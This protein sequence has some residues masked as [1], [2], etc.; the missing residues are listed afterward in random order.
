MS[1]LA[2]ESLVQERMVYKIGTVQENGFL[3]GTGVNSPLGVFNASD[4]GIGTDRDSSTNMTATGIQADG[5]IDAVGMLKAQYR[6]RAVWIAHRDFETRV[7]K[8]KD[9]EGNYL[10]R[11]GLDGSPGTLMGFPLH[12]SEY[13]PNAFTANQYVAI[14]GDFWFYW[15]VD[16]LNMQIQRLTELYAEDNQT[17]FIC[18]AE[19]DAMPI[20]A[21]AFVRLQMGS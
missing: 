7:R 1:Q 21:E 5:I 10:W 9:G 17:G 8:L 11:A 2:P 13:A 20:L 15:I 6:K 4:L 3:N 14:L 12:L 19:A 18:R 16:A